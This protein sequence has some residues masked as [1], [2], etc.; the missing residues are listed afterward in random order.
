MKTTKYILELKKIESDT[1]WQTKDIPPKHFPIYKKSYPNRA[2]WKW[3]SLRLKGENTDFCLF[4]H[5]NPFKDQWK[6]YLMKEDIPLVR[7]EYHGSHPGIHIHSSCNDVE[8]THMNQW[9]RLPDNNRLHRRANENYTESRFYSECI[10][11][12]RIN[13]ENGDLFDE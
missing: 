12:F 5:C 7:Y 10:K 1:N 6:A 8:K 3:R 11:V 13:T 9:I 4:L 2:S